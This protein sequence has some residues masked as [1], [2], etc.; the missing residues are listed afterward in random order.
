MLYST[1]LIGRSYLERL[2]QTFSRMMCIGNFLM[3]FSSSP[4]QDWVLI[5]AAGSYYS[6]LAT[7]FKSHVQRTPSKLIVN[8]FGTETNRICFPETTSRSV[9]ARSVVAQILGSRPPAWYWIGE[10][11]ATVRFL[12]TFGFRTIW[13]QCS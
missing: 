4:G 5:L 1:D 10:N 6:P 12:D 2:E 8:A 9:Y 11:A 3:V 13:V 7:E